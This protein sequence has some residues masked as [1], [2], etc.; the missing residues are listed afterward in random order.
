MKSILEQINQ[1]KVEKKQLDKK[2]K[3]FLKKLK[4]K[5][6]KFYVGGSYAKNTFLKDNLDIDIFAKFNYKKYHDKNISKELKKF[7]KSEFRRKVKIV[8]GSRDYFH[9]LENN[10]KFEIVPVLDIKKSSNSQNI[11]DFSPLHVKFVK[12]KTNRKKQN[13]IKILKY[14]CRANDLYGAESY[15]RGFS[16]Y[17]LE[18]LIIKYGSFDK[19]IKNVKTWKDEEVIYFGRNKEKALRELNKSKKVSPLIIIDPVQEDRNAAAA[20]S[21]KKL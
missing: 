4:N 21:K 20:I 8:H 12:K 10:L 13:E 18:L 19:L 6:I 2:V 9:I 7:L 1:N 17:V 14:F 16:G 3:E 11:M 15:I 5:D